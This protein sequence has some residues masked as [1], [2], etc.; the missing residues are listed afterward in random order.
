MR[1]II[2]TTYIGRLAQLVQSSALKKQRV[3]RQRSTRRGLG[4]RNRRFESC[5]PDAH[6][7]LR[8]PFQYKELFV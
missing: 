6:L 2:K 7:G 1:D 3:V 8:A 5:L 4:P